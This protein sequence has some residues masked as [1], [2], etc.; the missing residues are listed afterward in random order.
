M[1]LLQLPFWN[2]FKE[3]WEG[4]F[5]QLE[6]GTGEYWV[7]ILLSVC[8]LAV[9]GLIGSLIYSGIYGYFDKR[10]STK[11]TLS[12]ELVDKR[13]IGEQSLSGVGTAVIPNTSG[14]VGIGLVSTSSHS[15]EEFLF[16]VKADKV[17]KMEV[18]MKQF[19]SKNVGE[20]VRF[21]VTTGGL[22]K[23]E[24]DVELVEV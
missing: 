4:E 13:Y 22:S 18:D 10:S 12:G 15:Y 6:F 2:F 21:E 16:F 5:S 17:Y 1:K 20:K 7:C 23:D 19:Y 9:I 3:I 8:I 24:L 11:E 14:G